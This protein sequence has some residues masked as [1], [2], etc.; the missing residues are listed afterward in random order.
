MQEVCGHRCFE[1]SRVERGWKVRGRGTGRER[2]EIEEVAE[3]SHLCYPVISLS[4]KVVMDASSSPL[5]AASFL[6][7]FA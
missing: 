1:N 6:G 4:L 3:F 5:L 7:F 2:E